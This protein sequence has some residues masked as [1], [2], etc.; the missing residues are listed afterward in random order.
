[1][2]V[3]MSGKNLTMSWPVASAGYTLQSCTNLA[4]ANWEAVSSPAPQI[5]GTNYQVT[6]PATNTAQFFRLSM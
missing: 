2:A 3:S 4:P 6:L 5:V 1:M